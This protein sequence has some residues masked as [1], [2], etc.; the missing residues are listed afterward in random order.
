MLRKTCWISERRATFSFHVAREIIDFCCGGEEKKNIRRRMEKKLVLSMSQKW[1]N[2]TRTH[3]H[4]AELN[5]EANHVRIVEE[6]YEN[7]FAQVL[8]TSDGQLWDRRFSL[9]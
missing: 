9:F 1:T 3:T 6:T 2:S 8:N 5:C 7:N 4:E